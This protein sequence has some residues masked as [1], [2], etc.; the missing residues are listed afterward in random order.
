M[1]DHCSQG[2]M[3]LL[4]YSLD[5]IKNSGGY[6]LKFALCPFYFKPKWECAKGDGEDNVLRHVGRLKKSKKLFKQFKNYAT[7]Q[8]ICLNKIDSRLPIYS[9]LNHEVH[10]NPENF[11]FDFFEM[12]IKIQ[13]DFYDYKET[14][15]I[16]AINKKLH[17]E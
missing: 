7:L 10:F 12:D 14:I 3:E 13:H 16:S 15:Y 8:G 6:S 9:E 5:K 11:S 1:E 4:L 17:N 2:M